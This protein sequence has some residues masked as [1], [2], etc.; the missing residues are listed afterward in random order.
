MELSSKQQ[1]IELIKKSQK[2]LILVA[3]A[4]GDALGGALSLLLYLSR[5]GKEIQVAAGSAVPFSL[6][7]L[8]QVDKI[9]IDLAAARD[10][11]ITI[12]T[13]KT[14]V[15]KIG[16]KRE[17]G[18]VKIYI[19]PKNG[20][21]SD[22]QI[23]F[24]KSAHKFDLIIVLDCAD[25]E[26]LGPLFDENAEL[27]YETPV[28][29]IDHHASNDYF[30]KVNLIDLTATSTCE[31][32]VSLLEALNAGKNPFDEDIATLLL[33]GII[34]DTGSFQNSNTTPKS[35]TVAAQLVA[36]GARQQEII[37]NIFKTKKI[38]TLRLWGRILASLREDKK[39]KMVW[40]YAL[41]RDLE[42]CGAKEDEI[43]GAIDELMSSAPGADI[44][45]LLSERQDGIHG[46]IRT[47]R[48]VN[49]AEIAQIFGGGGHPGAAAFVLNKSLL[50]AEKEVLEKIRAFQ[51]ERC[52]ITEEST[53]SQYPA[54]TGE[55][56]YIPP[57][58]MRSKEKDDNQDQSPQ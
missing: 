45:L 35:F 42:Q 32:L 49:A 46:S 51:A 48:G 3:D 10:F 30:G 19:T 23:G 53:V 41:S 29:N 20:F 50:E 38:S 39:Y 2:I 44:I 28:I 11:V 7:F 4:D 21:L 52:G 6:S 18:K 24:S 25:L 37:K 43:S 31:I 47:V 1:T 14:D 55:P 15:E 13:A 54:K 27:F 33:T 5:S 40:S 12:D 17:D 58:V 36:A 57:E 56:D 9:L 16:Y 34:T 8:P 26:M 22:E